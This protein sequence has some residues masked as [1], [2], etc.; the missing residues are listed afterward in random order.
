MTSW[1]IVEEM[2]FDPLTKLK[3]QKIF[4]VGMGGSSLPADLVN[5]YL[6]GQIYMRIVRDYHLPADAAKGDLVIASSFSG[7]TEETIAA[8]EDSLEKGLNVVVMSHGGLLQKMALIHRLPFISIPA[9]IQ[10]RCATGYFFSTLLAFLEKLGL[11]N[12]QRK[13]LEELGSYLVERQD[14]YEQKGQ[15]L[16]AAL[17]NR[18]PIIYGPPNLYGACR[19]WKIKF[20]ENAKV[21]SF[22]NVFPELNHNEMVGFTQLIMNPVLIFLKSPRMDPRITKRMEI[23]EELLS[24]RIPIFTLALSGSNH[25]QVIFES[26]AV[27][28]YTSYYLAKA[29]GIDPIPVEMVEGFKKKLKLTM[30][31]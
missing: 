15:E 9:C 7:N 25:L 19:T 30:N 6:E 11:I 24:K 13:N 14:A 4:H 31:Q 23:M 26:L 21:Q 20:N 3:V 1:K 27:A 18:V 12:P 22:F 28:D 2:N 8:L 17:Q 10:P 29:Y 16:A 5:D